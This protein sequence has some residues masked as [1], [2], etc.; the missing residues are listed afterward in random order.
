MDK[1]IG[2]IYVYC[3]DFIINLANIF[4]LSYYEINAIIFC[5]LYPLLLVGFIGIYLFQ[6]RRL[7]N[8]MRN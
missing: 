3:T 6:K 7:N 2:E 8:L 4:N 1:L 5:F